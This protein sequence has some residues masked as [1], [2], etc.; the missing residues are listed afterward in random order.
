MC[1]G[2]NYLFIFFFFKLV[3]ERHFNASVGPKIHRKL[4]THSP[5][6]ESLWCNLMFA[7]ES[8]S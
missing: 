4:P 5:G 6:A 3:V 2:F 1:G 8:P 7:F